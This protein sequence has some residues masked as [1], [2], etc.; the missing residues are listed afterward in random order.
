ML[1][2]SDKN[3]QVHFSPERHSIRILLLDFNLLVFLFFY[4]TGCFLNNL[5]SVGL[6][7]TLF[8]NPFLPNVQFLYP[9]KTSENQRFVLTRYRNGTLSK[10]GLMITCS[11][12]NILMKSALACFLFSQSAERKNQKCFKTLQSLGKYY[13][14]MV[15]A[16]NRFL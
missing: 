1:V 7:L 6:Q 16:K 12:E 9:M 4:W 5:A 3:C 8:I 11:S 13:L 14:E 10:N 2:I 15:N